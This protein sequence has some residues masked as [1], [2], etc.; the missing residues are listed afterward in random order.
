MKKYLRLALTALIITVSLMMGGCGAK[1][2]TEK[3][4]Y[5]HE[6]DKEIL[7]LSSNGKAVY[8]ETGY[9]YTK[10]DSYIDLKDN[11]GNTTDLRYLIDGEK[12]IVYETS[13]YYRDGGETKDG[14]YGV[15]KQD[16]GWLFRFT[17]DGQFSE[18]DFFSGSY[19]I[20]KDEQSIK[21]MYSDPIP[22]AILYYSLD[23]DSLTIEYPWPMVPL[24]TE[25]QT[26][27]Q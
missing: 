25:E 13:T 7:S 3:W 21:L 18:E 2:T 23:G 17:K 27:S 15:W 10:D 1:V 19:R 16:N 5:D 20:N 22:D 26:D 12:M 11:S 8:K 24:Q 4:A 14:I 6:P 9:T